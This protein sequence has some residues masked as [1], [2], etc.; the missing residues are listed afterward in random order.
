MLPAL[1]N[2]P[3][4][5]GQGVSIRGVPI[6]NSHAG[7]VFWV[8][9]NGGSNG[10]KGTFDRPFSTIAYAVD[11]CRANK[12]DVIYV[13]A[14]HSESISTADID[15]DVNGVS[16]VGLGAGSSRPTI[17]FTGTTDTTTFDISSNNVLLHNFQI[18][19]ASCRERV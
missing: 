17:L 1:S 16:I 10:N 5:F 14:G 6:V 2:Y 12:G 9:S 7:K 15:V 13:K 4:G 3:S 19:R 11:Q 8:D 18:G